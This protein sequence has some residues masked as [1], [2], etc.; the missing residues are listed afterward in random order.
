MERDR[1]EGLLPG[2]CQQL[3]RRGRLAAEIAR[4][5]E[6][7]AGK[8]SPGGRRCS[9]KH[10]Q[11]N[12]LWCFRQY[13]C[14]RL[15][16]WVPQRPHRIHGAA[17][18]TRPSHR[19]CAAHAAAAGRPDGTRRERRGGS[20]PS[21]SSCRQYK[22]AATALDKFCLASAL[23]EDAGVGALEAA[24]RRLF[25]GGVDLAVAFTDVRVISMSES[26]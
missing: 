14:L 5:F 16:A 20:G 11:N 17:P 6:T 21:L 9:K 15:A 1:S 25:E 3:G 24:L 4:S 10:C 26:K 13:N 7:G 23:M 22:A 18:A 8:Q 19:T 2:F 12:R